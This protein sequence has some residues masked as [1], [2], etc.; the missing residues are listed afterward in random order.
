[1]L[2]SGHPSAVMTRAVFQRKALGI[3]SYYTIDF[4]ETQRPADY[5]QQITWGSIPYKKDGESEPT[6]AFMVSYRMAL[7][8]KEMLSH[9]AQVVVKA[10]INVR[11]FPG[12]YE[13]VTAEIPGRAKPEEEIL[14]IAHLDHYKPGANDNASGS[15]TLL[16]IARSLIELVK[17]RKIEPPQR[18]I[19]FMWVPEINGTMAY[20]AA[21][22]KLLKK[23]WQLSIW[24]W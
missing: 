6:F 15:S 9:G 14:F 22:L 19:K 2:A 18:T 4:Q 5:E 16:E 1:V 10:K 13:I 21:H 20:L 11:I 3:I 17:E 24:I 23:P 12:N 8:L 7:D